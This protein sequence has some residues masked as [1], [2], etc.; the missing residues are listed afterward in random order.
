MRRASGLSRPISNRNRRRPVRTALLVALIAALAGLAT[1]AH[2]PQAP[3]AA[4]NDVVLLGMTTPLTGSYSEEGLDQVRAARLALDEINAQGG[5]LG[6]RLDMLVRDS[7]SDTLLSRLNAVDLI[8]RGA[9]MVFGEASSAAAIEA[10]LVCDARGVPF[11]GALTYSTAT[12]L[13]YGRRMIFRASY[14]SWMA[15]RALSGLFKARF[16]GKRWFFITADYTWGWTTEDSLRQVAGLLDRDK[17][18]GVLKPLGEVDF[19]DA[20]AKAEAFKADVLV[21]FG[22]DMAHCLRQALRMGLKKNMQVVVPNLTLSMAERAGPEAMHGVVGT[23]SWNWRVPEIFDYPR[24]RAFV[25]AFTARWRR[26]PSTTG[27]GAYTIVYEYAAAVKRVGGTNAD[28]IVTA[29]E[30]RRHRLL[31]DDQVWRALDHQNVQT[32]YVV[33][34]NSPRVVFA[35]PHRLDYFTILEAVPGEKTVRDE[36]EWKRLRIEAGLPPHLG[37]APGEAP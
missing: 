3:L 20:L 11:F 22:K 17:H 33:E 32:T 14:D 34:G 35:D 7:A 28:R 4:D 30:G 5:V 24:G 16:A 2:P 18:P 15:A 19:R 9:V 21:L 13:E 12:T 23:T 27:A 37:P 31:K 25:E 26:R 8:D 36:A 10:G 6:K 29:L 1:L